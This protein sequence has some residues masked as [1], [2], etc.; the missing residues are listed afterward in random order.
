[1]VTYLSKKFKKLKKKI[2]R[3]FRKNNIDISD[4]YAEIPQKVIDK[5]S[6]LVQETLEPIEK[7]I[8]VRCPKCG[9]K[10]LV[11]MNADYVR[12]VIFKFGKNLIKL[13]II[14]PRL[15]CTNCKSTHAVLPDF[16]IPYKQYSKQAILEIVSYSERETLEEVANTLNITAKQVGRMRKLVK[17]SSNN[18]FLINNMFPY[19]FSRKIDKSSR[20]GRIIASLPENINEIYFREF[21]R[22]FLY[23]KNKRHSFMEYHR[24]SI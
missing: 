9:K 2:K 18:I 8:E 10:H 14:I 20:L 4:Q 17:D 13:K 15:R 11:P 16:C 19:L 24:L 1:M 23:A 7:F 21:K 5:I 12:N 3:I 6:T 22:Y